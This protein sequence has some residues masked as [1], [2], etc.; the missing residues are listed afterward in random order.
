MGLTVGLERSF[1]PTSS[2][3]TEA[4]SHLVS[5]TARVS[6]SRH[7]GYTT[8][9]PLNQIQSYFGIERKITFR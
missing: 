6:D 7:R 2:S 3:D 4:F 8:G 1:V 5:A 9:P